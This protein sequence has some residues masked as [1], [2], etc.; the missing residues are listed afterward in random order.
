[1][2]DEFRFAAYDSDTR[3]WIAQFQEKPDATLVI[4]ILRGIIKHY[5]PKDSPHTADSLLD[6]SVSALGLDSL[7]LMEITLDVQ[8]AFGASFSDEDLR[9]MTS[10]SEIAGLIDERVRA[11]SGGNT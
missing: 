11:L 4:P 9:H 2:N 1:M 6:E 10:F 5:L 7:T 8:D 3:R